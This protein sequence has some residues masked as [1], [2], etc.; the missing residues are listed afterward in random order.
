MTITLTTLIACLALTG[1]QHVN[2]PPAVVEPPPIV[3]TNAPAA[4]GIVRCAICVGVA[5][6]EDGVTCPGA[7]VD[8]ANAYAHCV[9]YDY[10][11]LMLDR[12]ACWDQTKEAITRANGGMNPDDLLFVPWSGHGGQVPDLNGDEADFLDEILKTWD[13]TVT[14]DEVWDFICTLRPCRLFLLTD[15]CSSEGNW[16]KVKRWA[17]KALTFGMAGQWEQTEFILGDE[18]TLEWPG[19]IIQISG[20]AENKSSLGG[21]D[22]GLLSNTMW[23][24]FAASASYA[25]WFDRTKAAMPRYQV[26]VWTEYNC[27]DEFRNERPLR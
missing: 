11:L 19:Q 24:K 25:D 4:A 1:C 3:S 22:G 12:S 8:A 14:D 26:P 9:G 21:D 18:R 23:A 10:R 16:R 17:V 2:W 6:A 27:S 20:C 5:L 7:D 15:T 13:R